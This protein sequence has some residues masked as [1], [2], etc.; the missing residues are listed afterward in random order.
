MDDRSLDVYCCLGCGGKFSDYK[1]QA[2]HNCPTPIRIKFET[3]KN[4]KG[5]FRRLKEWLW[6]P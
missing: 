4:K 5:V 1:A 3:K 2:Y 6:K